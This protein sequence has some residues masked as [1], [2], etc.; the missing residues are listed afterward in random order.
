MP[1][2]EGVRGTWSCTI[3]RSTSLSTMAWTA[4]RFIQR[5]MQR[6]FTMC[7]SQRL[8]NKLKQIILLLR[9]PAG[10]QMCSYF[11]CSE[12]SVILPLSEREFLVQVA[13]PS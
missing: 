1:Y 6:K 9:K 7:R 13:M 8:L 12:G 11:T 10:N 3:P 2:K 5:E 4:V